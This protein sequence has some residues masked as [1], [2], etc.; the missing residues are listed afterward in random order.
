[1]TLIVACCCTAWTDAA[2]VTITKGCPNIPEGTVLRAL[3]EPFDYSPMFLFHE[4]RQGNDRW[5]GWLPEF[6]TKVMAEYA[7]IAMTFVKAKAMPPEEA[8]PYYFY[9]NGT[10][11]WDVYF[12]ILMIGYSNPTS[13][14]QQTGIEYT[15]PMLTMQMTALTTFT[16]TESGLFSIFGPFT[17]EL[18]LAVMACIVV[19]GVLGTGFESEDKDN[20]LGVTWSGV[21][22]WHG[23]YYSFS[24]LLGNRPPS[25]HHQRTH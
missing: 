22:I 24:S 21:G 20:E 11:E 8:V 14:A 19:L 25:T 12:K 1:M 18:W 2:A 9:G 15:F 6:Q 13:V 16:E 17:G 23:F 5:S 4:S 7:Q 10:D 3:M